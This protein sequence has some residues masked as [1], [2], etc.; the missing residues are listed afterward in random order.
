MCFLLPGW[1]WQ[2]TEE[3]RGIGTGPVEA[4]GVEPVLRATGGS[5]EPLSISDTGDRTGICFIDRLVSCISQDFDELAVFV[6]L[7][8]HTV[9]HAHLL[10]FLAQVLDVA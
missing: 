7:F 6:D 5:E 3:E 10:Q 2:E 4:C 1:G 9:E 8:T